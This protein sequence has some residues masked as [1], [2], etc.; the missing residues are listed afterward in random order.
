M[1]VVDTHIHYWAEP[2]PDRPHDPEGIHWGAAI[3]AEMLLERASAAGVDRI[4]Q[5][6]PALM[7][8]DNRYGIEA[9][10]K[11]P[12]RIDG[13]FGRFDVLAPGVDARLRELMAQPKML[14]IRVTLHQPPY[15][16]WLR[17][18]TLE[19]FLTAAERQGVRVQL[20]VPYQARELQTTA[21]RFDG[22]QFMVDH[23]GIRRMPGEPPDRF[24]DWPNLIDLAREPNV[25][26]KVSYFPEAAPDHERYP[27][28]TSLRRFREYYEA[29]GSERMIWGSNYPPSGRACTY[30]E[31]VTFITEACEF[32]TAADRRAILAENF[33]RYLSA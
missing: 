31:S 6:T 23:M 14:G 7:G 32:L 33:S 25:W 21:R 10:L 29:T 27:F 22:I 17:D 26:I 11:Y 5:V 18:G 13:V 24:A 28:Q 30:R 3:T 2:T 15:D 19:P 20:F 1:T 9:A 16:T 8:F 4:V 12:D